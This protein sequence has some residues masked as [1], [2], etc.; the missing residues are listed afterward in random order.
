MATPVG[1]D[2]EAD[3]K[4]WYKTTPA[5]VIMGIILAAIIGLV[6][7]LLLKDDDQSRPVNSVVIDASIPMHTA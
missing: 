4:P 2:R 5:L 1:A 6:L 3:P 7:Y